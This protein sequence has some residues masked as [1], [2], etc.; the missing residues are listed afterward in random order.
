MVR[1]HVLTPLIETGDDD[2]NFVEPPTLRKWEGPG[3]N[4]IL[5]VDVGIM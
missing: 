1:R 4:V 3:E 5:D 2:F